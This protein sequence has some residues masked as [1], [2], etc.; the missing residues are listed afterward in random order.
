M[1]LGNGWDSILSWR[2]LYVSRTVAKKEEDFFEWDRLKRSCA[3][4]RLIVGIDD[5]GEPSKDLA[6]LM[7]PPTDPG[8]F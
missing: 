1:R 6:T 4:K 2:Y 3:V 8:R 7:G 5:C